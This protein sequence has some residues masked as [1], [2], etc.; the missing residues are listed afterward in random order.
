VHTDEFLDRALD[1]LLNGLAGLFHINAWLDAQ[2]EVYF[3][4]LIVD[5]Q[6]D[7]GA[8]RAAAQQPPDVN[9]DL[10]HTGDARYLLRRMA[11]NCDQHAGGNCN[12]IL[13]FHSARSLPG[14]V[15]G[16]VGWLISPSPCRRLP[17]AHA[18]CY[19]CLHPTR[20]T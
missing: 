17:T 5:L 12:C 3:N 10:P 14:S 13:W 4:I 11:G 16:A 7:A 18:L 9:G 2:V 19:S 20:G 15:K 8:H 6:H 1:L